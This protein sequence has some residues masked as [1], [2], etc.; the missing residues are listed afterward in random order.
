M[1]TQRI[2]RGSRE[3]EWG[4]GGGGTERRDRVNETEGG[5]ERAKCF[6]INN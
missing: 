1:D 2:D 6:Q 4:G 3:T 5:G